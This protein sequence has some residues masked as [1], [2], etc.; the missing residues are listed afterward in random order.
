[1]KAEEIT[2][3]EQ[4]ADYVQAM[5]DNS[6]YD[7]AEV[8]EICERNNWK[9]PRELRKWEREKFIAPNNVVCFN[10]VGDMVEVIGDTCVYQPQ[11]IEAAAIERDSIIYLEDLGDYIDWHGI[12]GGS[13]IWGEPLE[14]LAEKNGWLLTNPNNLYDETVIAINPQTE[15][16]LYLG[17]YGCAVNKWQREE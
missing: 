4:L 8:G 14:Q 2:T 7:S 5:L 9:Q 16:I 17:E 1:M 6:N 15:Y 11:Y 13:N 12:F 10:E 3:M